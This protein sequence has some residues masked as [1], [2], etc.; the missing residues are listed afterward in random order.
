MAAPTRM[1]HDCLAGQNCFN[2]LY[3]A[4]FQL[5]EGC[6]DGASPNMNF[7]DLDGIIE[8]RGSIFVM[9]WKRPEEW[10]KEYSQHDISSKLNRGQEGLLRTLARYDKRNVSMVLFGDAREMQPVKMM[11]MLGSDGRWR[12]CESYSQQQMLSAVREWWL[13][14]NG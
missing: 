14:V 13:S 8:R 10:D 12:M 5:F 9:E 7:T 2:E 3:R 6:F 1:R 4:R 11:R